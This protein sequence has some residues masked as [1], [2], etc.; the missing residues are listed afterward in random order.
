MTRCKLVYQKP[1]HTHTKKKKIQ[2]SSGMYLCDI[3]FGNISSGCGCTFAHRRRVD[4]CLR[5]RSVVTECPSGYRLFSSAT[6]ALEARKEVL[7]VLCYTS[8]IDTLGHL[9]TISITIIYA[10]SPDRYHKAYNCT[11]DVFVS[12]SIS[13]SPHWN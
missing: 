1:C 11:E 13:I 7:T 8:Q 9:N 10:S 12:C 6:H 3:T 4:C 5:Q 2:K